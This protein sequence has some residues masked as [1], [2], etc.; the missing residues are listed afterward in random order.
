M[1]PPKNYNREYL[2]HQYN[3]REHV[4]TFQRY[5]DSWK[6][7][8]EETR[9]RFPCHLDIHYANN[10]SETLDFFLTGKSRAPILVFIHGGYWQ[11]SDKS[12]FSYIAE[13]F[14]P[15][16]FN[17]AVLN[18]ILAPNATMDDIVDDIRLAISWIW[19]NAGRFSGDHDRIY[20]SG[21]SSGGHLA[22]MAL[23][24]DWSAISA[25]LPKNL[26][27]GAC[28]IS[29]L[30]DL[31]P[32]RHCFLNNTLRLDA[33]SAVRNSPIYHPPISRVPLILAVG[34]FETNEF[35]RQ[36]QAFAE[37]WKATGLPLKMIDMTGFNHYSIID[38][39]ANS[40][41]PLNAAVRNQV[42]L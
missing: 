6:R 17:L 36:T 35:L 29:G 18:H 37:H 40:K 28:A 23:L 27:K 38:E 12:E 31:E 30:F 25:A 39:L 22:A 14:V 41:S 11:G 32:I 10:S 16:G 13:G 26:I 20:I 34:S 8:S 3:N 24:T 2:D 19:K 21:H 33:A 15:L 7:R 1:I 42:S 5:F 9:R 4:P